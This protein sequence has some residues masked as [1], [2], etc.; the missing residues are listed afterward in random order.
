M[1]MTE[2]IKPWRRLAE[3]SQAVLIIGL[4]FLKING[5][6]ALRF[7]VP[8]LQLHFFGVSLW[9][10]E[11]FIVLVAV[12]FLSLLVLF[13]TLLFGRVWCGWVC[14]QTVISDLTSFVDKAQSK[15]TLY[16]VSAYSATVFISIIISANLIWYF[17]SP[18]EFISRFYEGSLGEIIWG[19]WLVLSVIMFLNFI[20]LR[21]KFCATVCPYAKLQSTMFDSRTLVV[22]FDQRR[23]DECIDC[24][25]CVEI[26][27]VGIDIRKGLN[28]ACIHCAECVDR[29]SNVMAPLQK[30]S[31]N[32]YFFGL[33][34]EGGK[35]FRLNAALIGTVTAVFLVLF[36]YLLIIR[37][38][39]DMTI[40]PN[41]S[42]QPRMGA[43]GDMINSYILSVKNMGKEDL[44]L[45]V[46][47]N[48]IKGFLK[49]MPAGLL[50]VRAGEMKKVPVYISIKSLKGEDMIYPL[51]IS[52]ESVKESKLNITKETNFI[53]PE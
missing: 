51:N 23:K 49:I 40:L 15:G 31:L 29:C 37:V 14:P 6:S 43:H 36:L 46:R 50:N 25:A 53:I 30:K 33:P 22:A 17:V 1:T 19:S 44:E 2:K 10:E 34:G 24:M 42:F 41:H 52:L 8:T 48:G 18:Y 12:I 20:W 16:K 4:P 28:I 7:D 9:M 3:T 5:E 45:K 21:Q 11:F 47:V 32:G 39:L 26:C 38:P 27:P 13:I 35:I